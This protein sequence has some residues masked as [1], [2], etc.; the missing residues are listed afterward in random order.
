M[1]KYLDELVTTISGTDWT[2]IDRLEKHL[3][4]IRAAGRTL[5]VCGN[6]GSHA[7]A[8]HWAVD[9]MKVAK[10]EVHAL[11]TNQAL[12][13]ALANDADYEV[14][15][16]TELSMRAHPGDVLVVLSCSGRSRN[17]VATLGEAKKLRMPAFM[18]TSTTAPEFLEV[19]TIRIASK[20]YGIL[21]DVFQAIGHHLTQV[22]S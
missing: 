7:V 11:G 6:G 18:I 15:L 13:T 22:M 8:T 17:I 20:D 12:L 19:N 21:E 4:M 1:V 16:S 9:L 10:L 5:F 3:L 2:A 14:G